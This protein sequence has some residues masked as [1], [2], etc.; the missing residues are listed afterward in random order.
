MHARQCSELCNHVTFLSVGHAHEVTP[1]VAVQARDEDA[2]PNLCIW[3][4]VIAIPARGLPALG[5][6]ARIHF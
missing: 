5:D 3:N 6:G 1:L 4:L 2:K